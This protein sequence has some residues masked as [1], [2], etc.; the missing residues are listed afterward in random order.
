VEAVTAAEPEYGRLDRILAA[1]SAALADE[2]PLSPAE[3]A[4]YRTAEM[5]VFGTVSVDGVERLRAMVA[6]LEAECAALT[7]ALG[8]PNVTHPFTPMHATSLVCGVEDSDGFYCA[9]SSAAAV[10][11]TPA[12]VRTELEA[13]RG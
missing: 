7:D 1:Q 6:A 9:L 4:A 8:D 2:P 5:V 12:V 11:R 13:G 3:Q 10:H